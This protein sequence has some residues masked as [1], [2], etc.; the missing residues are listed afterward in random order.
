MMGFGRTLGCL[1]ALVTAA[2]AQAAGCKPIPGDEKWPSE[3]L[4]SSLNESVGGRLIAT[5]PVGS[6]CH[7]GGPYDGH[8]DVAGCAALQ[9]T[10]NF[11]QAQ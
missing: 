9:Y 1:L 4:W 6:I 10:W 7:S 2:A 3:E 5:I 8:Y 11:A